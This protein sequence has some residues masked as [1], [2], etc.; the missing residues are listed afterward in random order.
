M[1]MVSPE[2]NPTIC[3]RFE[4]EIVLLFHAKTFH[5]GFQVDRARGE[6]PADR[7]VECL[8]GKEE[9]RTGEKAVVRFRFIKHPEYLKVGAKLLFTTGR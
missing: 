7:N 3:W 5:K 4:A 1:V 9:L 2:M 6:R 8:H